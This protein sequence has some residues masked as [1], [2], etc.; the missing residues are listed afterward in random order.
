LGGLLTRATGEQESNLIGVS[1]GRGLEIHQ[2]A[3]LVWIAGAEVGLRNIFTDPDTWG[4]LYSNAYWQIR[5][6]KPDSPRPIEL[7]NTEALDQA[8]RLEALADQLT[9]FAERLAAAPG[10]VTVVDTNVLLH[11]EPPVQVDWPAV[12]GERHVRLVLPLRVVEELDEKKY[13]ARDD[14]ADRARRLLAQLRTQL[15]STAGGP[16]PLRDGVTIEVPVDD[17]PRRRI[18]DADQEILYTC[19]QLR[20]VGCPVVLVTD[21]DGISIRAARVGIRVVPM[22]ERYLRKKPKSTR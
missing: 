8:M 10:K 2:N 11:F 9:R 21:D 12:V 17:G 7:I 4:G 5:D 6:L 19:D 1:A 14:I 16:V 22:P 13:T 3:Y 15:T 18:L 20:A